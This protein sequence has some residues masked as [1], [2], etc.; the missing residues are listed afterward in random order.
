MFHNIFLFNSRKSTKDWGSDLP[1]VA[2]GT[3]VEDEVIFGWE[4]RMLFKQI[5]FNRLL[6]RRR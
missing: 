1:T 3:M 4:L 2:P 5:K 6:F